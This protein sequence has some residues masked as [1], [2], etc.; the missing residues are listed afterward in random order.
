[1]RS[2]WIG[3]D[4]E[5]YDSKSQVEEKDQLIVGEASDNLSHILQTKLAGDP[6]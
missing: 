2:A 5:F 4:T 1:M 3:C 6:E